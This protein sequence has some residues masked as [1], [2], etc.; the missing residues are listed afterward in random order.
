MVQFVLEVGP[1]AAPALALAVA[2]TAAWW[3]L[4]LGAP[5]EAPGSGVG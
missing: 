4:T 3:G 1:L 2:A 5:A